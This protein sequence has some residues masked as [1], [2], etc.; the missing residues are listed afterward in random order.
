MLEMF[1]K[2]YSSL[3]SIFTKKHI[4][5]EMAKDDFVKQYFG[6][7]LGSIWAIIH[8]AIYVITI[9]IIFSL[10]IRKG[11]DA[12]HPFILYLVSGFIVWSFFSSALASVSKSIS[13]YKY[14]VKSMIFK[15]SVLP[16]VKILSSLFLHF[17]FL[18]IFIV[19]YFSNG[20]FPDIYVIQFPYYLSATIILLAG[21]GWACS[22]LNLFVNDVSQFISVIVRIGFWFTPIFWRID[23]FPV[24]MQSVLKLN[25]VFYLIQGYRDCFLYN[26]WFWER[27]FLTIYF[28]AVT[29][30]I[31]FSGVAIFKKL[32]PHFGD[33][34]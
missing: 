10:G 34:V 3:K 11:N 17:I 23:D 13:T 32:S 20:Y 6:S 4:I 2:L 29:L 8:P 27:P 28:W 30:I 24:G 16:I 21:L 33:V 14:L 12:E 7:Y 19:L 5:F 9:W 22:A 31:L 1:R 25:P 26:V 18:G 15:V